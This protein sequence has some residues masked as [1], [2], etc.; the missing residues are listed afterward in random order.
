MKKDRISINI[1]IFDYLNIKHPLRVLEVLLF[2]HQTQRSVLSKIGD[3]DQN[4]LDA[5][6]FVVQVRGEIA[7]LLTL[8]RIS[9]RNGCPLQLKT[10]FEGACHIS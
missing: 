9:N 6:N 1:L 2:S 8:Q 5:Q 4:Y 3:H 10:K 7:L